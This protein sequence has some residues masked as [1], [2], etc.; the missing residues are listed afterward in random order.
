MA[1]FPHPHHPL[2]M[3]SEHLL[4]DALCKVLLAHTLDTAS[5]IRTK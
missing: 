3:F 5:D 2:H 4:W 1:D